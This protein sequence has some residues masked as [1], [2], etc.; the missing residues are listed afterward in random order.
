M[1]ERNQN[2]GNQSWQSS[3]QDWNQNRNRFNQ[4]NDWNQNREDYGYNQ[5]R[6]MQS[7]R[8]DRD[9]GDDRY[10]NQ[11]DYSR[12]NYMPDNDE[13]RYSSDR[14]YEN[15]GYGTSG[16]YG[17]RGSSQGSQGYNQGMSG[18]GYSG[19]NYGGMSGQGSDYGKSSWQRENQYGGGGYGYYGSSG[20]QN[21]GNQNYG[22]RNYGNE[23]YGNMNREGMWGNMNRGNEGYNREHRRNRDWWDRTRDE[24]SSWFGDENAEQRRNM[25]KYYEGGHRGKGPKSYHRSEERIKE[26]VCD[27]LTDD[28]ML[29]ATGIEVEVH[30]EEV[31]LS[32]VVNNR[33]Q[34]RR[35]ED[36]VES[37][38]GVR[39][40]ENRL[41]VGE[42]NIT[43]TDSNTGTS[44]M[45][46][47]ETKGSDF[48]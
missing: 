4:Q 19:S 13:N 34:K 40:V 29:D 22:N 17:Y 18:M 41:R 20:N 5:E 46:S 16:T 1:A 25:D 15:T 43:L 7:S 23:S 48:R 6:R 47:R 9:Y 26:D 21:Y 30:G 38:S 27:R 28:D 33:M 35:A 31:T 24:V 11:N 45:L 44:G 14:D 10:S 3:D 39:N 32:G 36:L 42:S 2:R 37:V 8:R 12:V